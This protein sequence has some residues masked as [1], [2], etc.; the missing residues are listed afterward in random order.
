M[1][2]SAPDDGGGELILSLLRS[3]GAV[4]EPSFSHDL[5]AGAQIV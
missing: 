5:R 4:V 1:L 3:Y 2:G